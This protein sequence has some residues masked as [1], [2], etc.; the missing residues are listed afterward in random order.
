MAAEHGLKEEPPLDLIDCLTDDPTHPSMP[1]LADDLMN[2]CDNYN[3][4]LINEEIV[5]T[6][7]LDY[8]S[9][10]VNVVLDADDLFAD[11]NDLLIDNDKDVLN[12]NDYQSV[13]GE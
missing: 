6:E 2:L 12:G 7:T 8:A 11:E 3:L 9:P 5:Y 1:A 4:Y 10:P 13:I